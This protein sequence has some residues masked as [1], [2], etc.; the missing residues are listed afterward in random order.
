MLIYFLIKKII[1]LYLMIYKKY[2][3]ITHM[4]LKKKVCSLGNFK[5]GVIHIHL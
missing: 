3:R 2:S 5:L 1:I 4:I